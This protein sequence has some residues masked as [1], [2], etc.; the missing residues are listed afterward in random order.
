MCTEINRK[1]LLKFIRN[2]DTYYQNIKR[3]KKENNDKTI[4]KVEELIKEALE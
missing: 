4:Q 3:H 1:I 2:N